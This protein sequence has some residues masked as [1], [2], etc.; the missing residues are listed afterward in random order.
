[1]ISTVV[2][3]RPCSNNDCSFCFQFSSNF[4][5]FVFYQKL[6]PSYPLNIRFRS[7]VT[8][9]QDFLLWRIAIGAR[10][11]EIGSPHGLGTNRMTI[12]SGHCCFDAVRHCLLDS[13]E[14]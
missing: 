11:K 4:L 10:R 14:L 5:P 13:F 9:F 6:S 7:I 1:M 12:D 2:K 8:F 3:E